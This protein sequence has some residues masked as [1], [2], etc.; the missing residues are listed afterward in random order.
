MRGEITTA[1]ARGLTVPA[2]SLVY[3]EDGAHV[4]VVRGGKA[5]KVAVTPGPER[6]DQVM[7]SG[8]LTARDRVAVTGAYQLEDGMA[9]RIAAPASAGPASAGPESPRQ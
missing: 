4:F 5:H 8:A 9:V 3:D 6:A 1:T 7:V 2:A